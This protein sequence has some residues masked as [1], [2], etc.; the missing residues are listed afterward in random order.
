MRFGELTVRTVRGRNYAAV[1]RRYSHSS[2]VHKYS[3]GY[4]AGLQRQAKVFCFF[5]DELGES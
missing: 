3:E 2:A 5:L 4:K 1:Q